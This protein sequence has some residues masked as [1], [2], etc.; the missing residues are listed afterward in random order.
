MNLYVAS[1]NSFEDADPVDAWGRPPSQTLIT[2]SV[3]VIFRGSRDGMLWKILNPV[4]EI[5]YG[6]V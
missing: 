5:R 2:E 6:D 1:L 3:C 4:L